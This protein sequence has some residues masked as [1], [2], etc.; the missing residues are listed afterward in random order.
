M[1][2]DLANQRIVMA[3]ASE[4]KE[5]STKKSAAQSN[6]AVKRPI[7]GGGHCM[8]ATWAQWS[9]I[10][11]SETRYLRIPYGTTYVDGSKKSS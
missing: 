5:G 6:G 4:I 7:G 2:A 11:F 1:C 8:R 10:F 9:G 3:Y